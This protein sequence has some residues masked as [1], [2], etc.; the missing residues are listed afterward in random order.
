[1]NTTWMKLVKAYQQALGE[2]LAHESEHVLLQAHLVGRSA[3]QRGW[4]V[5]DLV[6][7]HQ[8]ALVRL[9]AGTPSPSA[10]VE[11]TAPVQTFL[12]EALAPFEAACRGL[13]ENS[14]RLR[15]LNATLA[16]RTDALRT[17]EAQLVT[18]SRERDAATQE[19]RT[20]KEHYCHLLQEARVME[21]NFR[22]LSH[23][24]LRIQEEE[25]KRISR[26]LHDELG[27]TLNVVNV[28]L[29]VLRD[30]FPEHGA[31]RER[32]VQAQ[33]LLKHTME[34]V[35]RFAREL[36]PDMLDHLGFYP[37]LGAYLRNFTERTGI[38]AC[39]QAHPRR[40][41]LDPQ[42]A[43][44]LF[45]VAQ[46]SLSNVAKHARATR[47]DIRLQRHRGTMHMEIHDNGRSFRVPPVLAEDGQGRLGLLGMEERV[48]LL[49]GQF[50]I[51][52]A[53]GCGTTVCVRIPCRTRSSDRPGAAPRSRSTRLNGAAVR[54][55]KPQCHEKNHRHFSRRPHRR[56]SR[57]PLVA[58]R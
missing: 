20:S 21:E 13:R 22:Q 34:I 33:R 54:S 48:R 16:Q 15:Q 44:V 46:E 26:E 6:H 37:A 5:L 40:D 56:P 10:L 43:I 45:R 12:L 51:Q 49:N 28:S 32:I 1:M 4:G 19:L 35:R 24:V 11:R 9:L 55:A 8:E 47:V 39:L 36:R 7:L 31:I 14:V 50:T 38:P 29:A 41:N 27:Q 2:Y 42:E 58:R 57:A 17:T 25:R 52:S 30:H 3:L 53:P 18:V 23:K